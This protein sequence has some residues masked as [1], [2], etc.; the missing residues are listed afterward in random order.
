MRKNQIGTLQQT[1]GRSAVWLARMVRDHEVGGSSPL[2]PTI[3]LPLTG[4]HTYAGTLRGAEGPCLSCFTAHLASLSSLSSFPPFRRLTHSCRRNSIC[5]LID[6]KSSFAQAAKSRHR[7]GDSRR[8]TCFLSLS[9]AS[10]TGLRPR[11]RGYQYSDPLFTTG[12]ASLLPHRTTNRLLT[13]AAFRSSSSATMSS[14]LS[15]SS[16]I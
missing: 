6:R 8:R 1:S 14:W 13:M 15:R 10:V 2:A 11:S 7:A 12:W 16:A 5:P 9:A 3:L 4:I